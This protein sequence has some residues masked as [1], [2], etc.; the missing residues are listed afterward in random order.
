MRRICENPLRSLPKRTAF[1]R[2]PVAWTPTAFQA[3]ERDLRA[4]GVEFYAEELL[5]NEH[6]VAVTQ[7]DFA[8]D[9]QVGAVVRVVVR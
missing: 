6:V 5:A 1:V 8:L 4:S 7:L 3:V 9:A 2:D